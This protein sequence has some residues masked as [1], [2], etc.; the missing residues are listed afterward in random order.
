MWWSRLDN[1]YQDEV[2]RDPNTS[3][4]AKLTIYDHANSNAQVHTEQVEL[5]Y[6]AVFGPDTDDVEQ[7]TAVALGLVS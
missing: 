1:R 5:A 3:S 7:W 4:H 2:T 6:G